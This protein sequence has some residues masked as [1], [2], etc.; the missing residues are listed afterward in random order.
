[1]SLEFVAVGFDIRE[2]P[3]TER[4][5]ADAT[6]WAQDDAVYEAAKFKLGLKEN[7]LQLLH[8][9]SSSESAQL[10]RLISSNSTKSTLILI[11]LLRDTAHSALGGAHPAEVEGPW[12]ILGL[13]VCDLNGFF[14]FLA[15]TDAGREMP[16]LQADDLSRALALAELANVTV[17]EHRPFVV[18]QLKRLVLER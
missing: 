15:M 1:M 16:A 18:A 4:V 17:P 9:S 11:E 12:E 3:S 6:E 14:S 5:T 10:R 8:P 13:D 7:R 2:W